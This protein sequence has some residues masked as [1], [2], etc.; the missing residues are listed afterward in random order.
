MEVGEGGIQ[1]DRLKSE[2]LDE[3]R[4]EGYAIFTVRDLRG[5]FVSRRVVHNTLTN[6]ARAAMAKWLAATMFNTGVSLPGPDR[7]ALGTGTGT[8]TPGDVALFAETAGTRKACAYRQTWTDYTAEFV[9]QYQSTDPAGTFTEEGLFD[10]ASHLWAHL[11]MAGV[12]KG[13]VAVPPPQT[14]TVQH[15]ILIKGN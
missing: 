1:T 14:L 8:T 15:R 6:Y 4:I 12:T 3:T 13:S 11:T 7:I 10:E 5:R 2:L 9:T